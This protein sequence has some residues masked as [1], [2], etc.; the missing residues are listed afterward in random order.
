VSSTSILCDTCY[1]RRVS[2]EGQSG[3]L[4]SVYI[5]PKPTNKSTAVPTGI[6]ALGAEYEF[7]RKECPL[8]IPP[9]RIVGI[10][11]RTTGGRITMD[12]L[13]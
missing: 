12:F 7:R 5:C 3:K 6:M 1:R 9:S 10:L 4:T 8:G 13:I 11:R 2:V